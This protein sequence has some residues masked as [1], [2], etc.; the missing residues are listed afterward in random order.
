MKGELI[1]GPEPDMVVLSNG[2]VRWR[3]GVCQALYETREQALRR[4]GRRATK[5]NWGTGH[6][7]KSG[8]A[9]A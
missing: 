8:P 2:M 4:Y 7:C 9:A 3:C 1:L 6:A 5:S